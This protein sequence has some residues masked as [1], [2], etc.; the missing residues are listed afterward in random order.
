MSNTT[1]PTVFITFV[2]AIL[3]LYLHIPHLLKCSRRCLW[4]I[5]IWWYRQETLR[6]LLLATSH[7]PIKCCGGSIRMGHRLLLMRDCRSLDS[8]YCWQSLSTRGRENYSDQCRDSS[9][10]RC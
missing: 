7:T 8:P 1:L 2:Q 4:S 5:A 6:R 3:T 9:R 10:L